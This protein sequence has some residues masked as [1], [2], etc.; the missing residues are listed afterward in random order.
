[1]PDFSTSTATALSIAQ[2]LLIA[3][4]DKGPITAALITEKVAIA[5]SVVANGNE[6]SVDNAAAVAELIRRFS[7]WIGQDTALSDTTGHETWLNA[8]RKKD[9]RYWPRYRDMLERR[10][11]AT[12]VDAVDKSTDRILGLMEDP[13][14]AGAWDRRGLVVGHV[15]SGKTANY[16][17]LICKAADSGYKIII[18]LAGLHN[19]LRSQ[20]QIRLEEG[21]LGYETSATGDIV[22]LVGVGEHGRD[23]EI[24][25]NCATNRTNTGDF[26]TRI[27]KH[28]AISPEQRPWLF[29]VKKHKIVLERLLKWIRGHVADATDAAGKRFVSNLPL[30]LIDDEADH[31]SVDTGE[32]YIGP[33]G[34]P[35]ED[36]E[37]KAIN[38][39]IRKILNSFAKKA[40]VGYTA[41][42]FANIFIHRQ[43]ETP[44][45]GPDLFPQS[46]IINLAA[47]SNYVGPARVFGLQTPEGRSGLPLVRVFK[48]HA[49]EDGLE[50]WMPPRHPK[51]HAPAHMGKD[52][53]PP[54]LC[55]AV[56]AFVLACAA[57]DARGQ[58]A[59]HSS[60]LVHVTRYT[61]VQKEVHRQVEDLVQKMKLRISR[62][63]DH[64]A[65]V[66]ELREQWE[67]DFVP[68]TDVIASRLTES[69]HPPTVVPW[70]DILAK[71]PDVLS[72]IDVRMVNGKAKDAL[73]YAEEGAKGLKVIAIGGDKLARG[74]TL[75]GLCTSYFVR[76]TKMYDTLMQMGRWFG[77]RPGYIDLCRLYTTEELVEWFGHIADASEELR[78]E[79]D[80]MAES[81]ATPR[82]YGMRVQSHPILLVT[83]PLKMRTARNLQL[84]FSGDLLETVSMHHDEK[85]LDQNLETTDKLIAACGV[86]DEANPRRER[87]A[88]EQQWEGFVWN[89]VPAEHIAEFFESFI[90]HP[91]ARKVNSALLRDFVRSMAAT[92]E[93]T[94]WT[95]ALLGGGSG[96][97]H[98]FASGL[99]IDAMTKRTADKDIADRYAI[100][101][102]LSPRDEA[103]DLDSAA[104]TAALARTKKMFNP[105]AGRLKSG[106]K[107]SEP[108]TPN[109]PSIRF[110]RG[111]GSEADGVAPAPQRG[112]LLLYPLDPQ[113]AGCEALAGRKNPVMAFGVSFPSSDSGVKV[114]YAVD[115]LLWTQEYGPAD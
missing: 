101:R 96:G 7:L 107:P 99:T 63:I 73:D 15:Q 19:N 94:S 97:K 4:K 74:L 92:G 32:Q 60:M 72:D 66:D 98:T 85:I 53:P 51:D 77:Y 22:K 87:G 112:L 88:Q 52:V 18:V 14:R 55:E 41:T 33:D 36:H 103:I 75:E 79:F 47:P 109:G 26:N 31:A 49:T 50:G 104:W 3:E 21:F 13:G 48:D 113:Q 43:N 34:K 100:G 111:K 93:L 5:A 91:R 17:G 68:T 102:L 108:D 84:S 8:A 46:F 6:Q 86:P 38:S 23:F 89:D 59:E 35:D 64:E 61:L 12:A 30:L 65:L 1:M 83:S 70:A 62:K 82:D 10:M 44:E 81:G 29:V 9:W 78:E 69:E 58:G 105:D 39:R 42:P 114:E 11:A 16:S 25:P 95:V 115:H 20:T 71:L 56:R 110:I 24:K 54:S 27:A 76:T 90:T 28:L 45:E 37:P 80:A 2:S 57:R 67:R 106:V 40:Y